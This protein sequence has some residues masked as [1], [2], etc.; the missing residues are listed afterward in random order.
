[1]PTDPRRLRPGALCR[2]L[3]STPLGAVLSEAQ[4]R[5]HRS[6]AGL[7]IGEGQ[8]LDLL[9]YVAW[10]VLQRHAPRPAANGVAEAASVRVEAAEGAGA[11]GSRRVQQRGNHPGLTRKQEALIAALLTEPTH[12]AAA[13]RA[14]V[15]TASLYRWLPIPTFQAAYQQ[16]R[17]EMVDAAVGRA[18]AATGNAVETLMAVA[19]N[20]RR[21]GDR[22]RAAVALLEHAHRGLA[23]AGVLRGDEVAVEA[24][25]MDT[26][27]LVRLLAGRLRQVNAADLPTAEKTRLTTTLSDALLRALGVE[28]IDKRLQAVQAVL[29]ARKEKKKR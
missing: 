10:L 12:T 9:R 17:R 21:D 2:L 27:E 19:S 1:V 5:R 22:V 24:G 14:G 28:V 3:N 8:H 7:R 25:P 4:L 11:L 29:N 15:S 6:R 26:A 13:A 18:Q 16:A 20:G 23:D